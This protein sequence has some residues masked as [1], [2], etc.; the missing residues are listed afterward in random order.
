MSAGGLSPA[1]AST[2]P[3]STS[4]STAATSAAS[5]RSVIS[6]ASMPA[7]LPCYSLHL[8]LGVGEH[9]LIIS[10]LFDFVG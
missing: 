7:E 5:G 1:A 4:T 2:S 10:G 3:T 8:A 6:A 9:R